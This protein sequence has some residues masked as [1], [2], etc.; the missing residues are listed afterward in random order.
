MRFCLRGREA[1]GMIRPRER[2]NPKGLWDAQR[3]TALARTY[4]A[5]KQFVASGHL[6]ILR[7]LDL[8]PVGGGAVRMAATARELAHDALEVVR[9]RDPEEVPPPCLDV[10]HVRHPRRH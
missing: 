1:A 6:R 4:S 10:I 9:T 7:I 5:L 8:A 3:Q 2:A